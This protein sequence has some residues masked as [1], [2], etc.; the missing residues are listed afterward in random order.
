MAY[1]KALKRIRRERGLTAQEAAKAMGFASHKSITDI[2]Y[3]LRTISKDELKNLL[4]FYGASESD[5]NNEKI[6]LAP[7]F[8]AENNLLTHEAYSQLE[9]LEKMLE[10]F[11][12]LITK[13]GNKIYSSLN[14]GLWVKSDYPQP[15][16]TDAAIELGERLASQLRSELKLGD[17][18]IDDILAITNELGIKVLGLE[19]NSDKFSGLF[20]NLPKCGPIIFVNTIS[21]SSNERITFSIAHELCHFL[22]DNPSTMAWHEFSESFDLNFDNRYYKNHRDIRANAFAA[23]LLIPKTGIYNFIENVLTKKPNNL[24]VLDIFKI[25][26]KYKTSLTAT[27]YRLLNLKIISRAAFDE[28]SRKS[29]CTKNPLLECNPSKYVALRQN[30]NLGLLIV[31]EAINAY[32]QKK[33]SLGK[34]QEFAESFNY[35]QLIVDVLRIRGRA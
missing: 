26:Q 8:R 14:W 24:D 18:A 9:I 32:Y 33:I 15:N 3:D 16:T 19:F 35:V 17:A 1:G 25:Q 31:Q 13:T 2:E 11:T 21:S 4:K 29:K 23:S 27:L 12:D 30:Q 7:L 5:L 6:K 20:I 22:V 10:Q 28:L 34:L